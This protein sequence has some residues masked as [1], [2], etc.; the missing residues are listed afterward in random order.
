MTF[1]QQRAFRTGPDASGNFG[2]FGGRFV[3]ETLMPLLLQLELAYAEAR[4]D[5][6]FDNEWI[7]TSPTTSDVPA[8]CILQSG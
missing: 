6:E 5:P 4:R 3:P 1:Q 8:R 7:A 2:D